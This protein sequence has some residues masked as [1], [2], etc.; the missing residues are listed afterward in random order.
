MN[1]LDWMVIILYM[2]SLLTAA[3]FFSRRQVSISDYYTASANM[4]WWQAGTSSMATQ[5]GAISFVSAPAFVAI[6]EGGGLKWLCYELGVPFGLVIVMVV[7]LPAL[8]KKNIISIYEYLEERFDR[9]T[10]TLVSVCFQLGRSLATAVA[11]LAGGIIISTCTHLSTVYAICIMGFATIIY[12]AIGGIKIVIISDVMQMLIIVCGITVCLFAG[13]QIVGWQE[14]WASTDAERFKILEFSRAGITQQ[15]EYSFWPM[16]FGGIFLYASYYGCDQSQMQRLL[17][18]SSQK[19]ARKSILLNGLV[20]FP[21]V[22]TYCLMG[23]IV[24]AAVMQPEFIERA[25]SLL[26]TDRHAALSIMESDPDRMVPLFIL[27]YLPHGIIGFLFVA[28]ISALMSSLDSAINSLSATTMRDIYQ[29]YIR[30]EAD[31]RHYFVMS[32]IFT[33]LWGLFCTVAA[34]L[35]AGAH[36]ALRQTTIVLINA[37][38]SLLYGPI[39]AAF[40]LGVLVKG[41][42][43]KAVKTGI[44]C[45]IILNLVLWLFTDISWLWWNVTGCGT[46]LLSAFIVSGYDICSHLS[47]SGAVSE[48][49]IKD[50]SVLT[51]SAYTVL[52]IVLCF[53][54]QTLR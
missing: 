24:G 17:T 44:I 36:D 23:I 1:L 12:D 52:I 14:A 4:R 22:L 18:V 19:E 33:V 34:L 21:V 11:V 29:P 31:R 7:L 9:A 39:L 35:F 2:S 5:L 15:G 32:K 28:I 26:S 10:R 53:I 51:L 54:I 46:A 38:G 47:Y 8:Y 45:G 50:P 20:R 3:I 16:F 37:V 30:P 43:A 13:L 49:C 48:K 6:K 27:A 42:K 25:A 40:M 41:I